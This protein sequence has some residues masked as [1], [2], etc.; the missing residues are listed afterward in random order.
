MTDTTDLNYAVTE[1]IRNA[2]GVHDAVSPSRVV[3]DTDGLHLPV[4]HFTPE[5]AELIGRAFM[6]AAE[7]ARTRTGPTI[8]GSVHTT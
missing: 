1:V 8:Y 2:V 4:Y 3:F 6:Q 5:Q 7:L